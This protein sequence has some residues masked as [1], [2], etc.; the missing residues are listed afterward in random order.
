M[1][2]E[3]DWEA[4]SDPKVT[5]ALSMRFALTEPCSTL[6]GNIHCSKIGQPSKSADSSTDGRIRVTNDA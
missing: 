3:H 6:R 4:G 5:I 2:T 1:T